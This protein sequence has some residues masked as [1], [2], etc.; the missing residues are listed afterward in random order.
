M[1]SV[2]PSLNWYIHSTISVTKTQGIVWNIVQKD[3][4][5]QKSKKFTVHLCLLEMSKK[6]RQH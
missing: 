6:G 2:Y 5:S 4:N 3:F 1:K